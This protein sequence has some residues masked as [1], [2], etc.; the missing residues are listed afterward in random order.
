MSKWYNKTEIKVNLNSLC[1]LELKK[2]PEKSKQAV[3]L[4]ILPEF[5]RGNKNFCAIT[6]AESLS[7]CSS[8]LWKPSLQGC[9]EL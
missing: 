5:L 4:E 2:T 1:I 6:E 7:S 3:S 8:W 9:K